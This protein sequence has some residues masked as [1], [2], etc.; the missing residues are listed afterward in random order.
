VTDSLFSMDGDFAPL[1]EIVA[2]KQR[3]RFMLIVDEAHAIGVFGPTGRGVCELLGVSDPVDAIIGTSSKSLGGAGGFIAGRRLLI[4]LLR[5]TARPFIFSTAPPA[6]QA[7][8][9]IAAVKII[10]EEPARRARLLALSAK[11]RQKMAAAGLNSPLPRRGRDGERGSPNSRGSPPTPIIPVILGSE[12]RALAAQRA[13][14]ARDLFV[15][16]IRPPTVPKGT[17]RLR[18]SLMCDHTEADLDRLVSALKEVCEQI[19]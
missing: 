11:L 3:F 8:A 9:T 5:N 17:S 2:L 13:L 16:A 15:L 12:D 1:A 7:A 14:L 6:A 4:D 10:R 18:I 19:G